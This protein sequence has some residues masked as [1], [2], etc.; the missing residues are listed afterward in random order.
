MKIYKYFFLSSLLFSISFLDGC[1]IV[2]MLEKN[3]PKSD[4]SDVSEIHADSILTEKSYKNAANNANDFIIEVESSDQ[5]SIEH[6][7]AESVYLDLTNSEQTANQ[8]EHTDSEDDERNITIDQIKEGPATRDGITISNQ[9]TD[10]SIIRLFGQLKEYPKGE[11]KDG[12]YTPEGHFTIHVYKY[13]E[14]NNIGIYDFHKRHDEGKFD[15]KLYL[16]EGPGMYKIVINDKFLFSINNLDTADHSYLFPT[17]YTESDHVEIIQLAQKITDGLEGNY[18]KTKAIH[19][20]VA[21]NIAYDVE[22]D[23]LKWYTALET[24]RTRKA[25]CNGYAHLTIALNRAIGI[26]AKYISGDTIWLSRGDTWEDEER[27][28][29]H[30]WVETFVNDRWIIQDPTWDSGYT[31]IDTGE[32]FTKFSTQ[33]FDVPREEFEKDHKKRSDREYYR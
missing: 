16:L 6:S 28:I 20:W 4:E 10:S 29:D 27:F 19:D 3:L 14:Q 8:H 1:E 24:L 15:I 31:N 32:Y 33:Y 2:E 5:K 9:V 21:K 7:V 11:R 12:D 30:A 23:Q 18:A 13:G 17:N 22:S 25:I 26:K